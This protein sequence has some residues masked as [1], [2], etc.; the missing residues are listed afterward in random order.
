MKQID[1]KKQKLIAAIAEQERRKEHI[2][3]RSWNPFIYPFV[4]RVYQNMNPEVAK[5][6]VNMKRTRR[7]N[8]KFSTLLILEL[9]MSEKNRKMKYRCLRKFGNRKRTTQLVDLQI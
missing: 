5:T 8:D 7:F 9:E 4:A 1:Q 3:N 2:K 6:S